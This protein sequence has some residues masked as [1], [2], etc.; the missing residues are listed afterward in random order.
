MFINT[1]ILTQYSKLLNRGFAS[2]VFIARKNNVLKKGDDWKVLEIP[3]IKEVVTRPI[4]VPE[5][6]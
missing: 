2:I 1:E 5:Q 3:P 4:C 6:W